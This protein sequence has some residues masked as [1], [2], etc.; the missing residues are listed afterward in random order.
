METVLFNRPRACSYALETFLVE[1]KLQATRELL[2]NDATLETFLVE[3]KL[4]RS[5]SCADVLAAP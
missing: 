4:F 5:C 2:L 1:W 3:W